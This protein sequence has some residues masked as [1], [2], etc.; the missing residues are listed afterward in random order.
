MLEEDTKAHTARSVS[1]K[2]ELLTKVAVDLAG[3]LAV[4]HGKE[5]VEGG[6]LTIAEMQDT[7]GRWD[8][9]HLLINNTPRI[10]LFV[11]PSVRPSVTKF[12]QNF[13]A[14]YLGNEKSYRRSA[15]VKT[16]KFLRAFWIF[17]RI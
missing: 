8:Q 9:I 3:V 2:P 16:T 14:R 1:F 11:G 10:A 7:A 13:S 5:A 17:Q 15:G 4:Q 12:Q 6:D